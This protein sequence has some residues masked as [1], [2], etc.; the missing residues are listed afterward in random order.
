MRVFAISDIHIDFK[1]NRRWVHNLS[2]N[3]Y[4]D[5]ILILAGDV[6]DIALLLAEAF[7]EL[8]NRFSEV[9]YVNGNHD[10]WVR[11]RN[12]KS[13][14]EKFHLLK[15]IARDCGIC[16]EPAHFGS[17]SV[18][19]LF[20]W[21]DYSF[22]QPSDD[23]LRKWADYS[24]CKWP[25]DFDET[26][27]THHFISM[28]EAFLATRNRFVI[29]FSHFLPRIDLM[30]LYIP[31]KK[32]KLYPVLGTSML[33]KQIRK[34]DSQVHIYGHSHVNRRVLKDN[35][36]YINN[37]FGYPRETRIT[38]KKLYCVFEG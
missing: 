20:G 27:I 3:D 19:P 34:L 12:G 7:Q 14:L 1:E 10:L 21:Y 24:Y 5:D 35:T 16:M 25:D 2:Q 36:L 37:A 4:K 6:T 15:T 13:S 32:R 38:A 23:I 28:N 30:P 18:V 29:S 26:R 8:K 33:E 11:R 17:L 22:G 9:L 31:P